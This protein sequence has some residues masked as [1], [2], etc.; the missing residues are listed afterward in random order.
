MADITSES[1]WLIS[2][3]SGAIFILIASPFMFNLTQKLI[4]NP[5]KMK[6][7]GTSGLPTTLGLIVHGAVY[8]LIVRLMMVN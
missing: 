7:I 4:G 1:K 5:L 2:L 6:F 3:M 8:T